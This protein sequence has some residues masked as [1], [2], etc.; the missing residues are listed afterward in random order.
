MSS[1]LTW[2]AIKKNCMISDNTV[3]DNEKEHQDLLK[4]CNLEYF[5][6]LATQSRIILERMER[7]RDTIPSF[8]ISIWQEQHKKCIEFYEIIE[9]Y[10]KEGNNDNNGSAAGPKGKR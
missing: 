8:Y 10:S 2:D 4:Y 3:I 6:L 1:T 5:A 9:F 7:Y